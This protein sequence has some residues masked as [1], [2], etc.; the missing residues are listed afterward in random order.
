MRGLTDRSPST[1][2]AHEATVLIGGPRAAGGGPAPGLLLLTLWALVA[3]ACFHAPYAFTWAGFLTVV[4]LFALLQ[5]AKAVRWRP[6][7]YSGLAVGFLIA[8]VRLSFF[9]TIFS[10]G[11]VS[12]WLVFA[13]WIGL[14]V[15]LAR[16][17]LRRLPRPW[18]WLV[19]PF[20]WTGLE[21]FRSELYYLRFAWLTPGFAFAWSLW[22]VP[23]K[24]AGVYGVGFLL[25]A[26]AAASA[27]LWERSKL[28][29]IGAAI[30]GV[31]GLCLLGFLS[32]AG[33][34]QPSNSSVSVAGVQLELPSEGE[35]LT[36]LEDLARRYPKADLLVL[37]EYTLPGPVPESLQAWCRRHQ[38]Y[39]LVGGKDPAGA[40]KFYNTAF[41]VG[42][43]GQIVFR[44]AKSV[45]IQFFKDGL[46]ARTQRVW[47]SPWGR[48]GI[49]ICYDL[50]YS[51]VT[52]RLVRLGAQALIVPTM[53]T[54]D[55]GGAEHNLHARVAPIRAAEYGLPVFR[56]ASSG[57]S[58]WVDP[59]GL[60][61]AQA[62]FPGEGAMI[63]G[64]L[65]M[66]DHGTLPWDRWLGPVSVVVAAGLLCWFIIS[67]LSH[68]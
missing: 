18:N 50:S 23:L 67:S 5:L 42:P 21:Y 1:G 38:R 6:A 37:S 22:E 60:V 30:A 48:I 40:G 7:F 33:R 20:V 14:F 2:L 26:V 36:K 32:G 47:D 3:A 44:Q 63:T 13:F 19:L 62:P 49:C 39:L 59:T 52:D 10:A 46:P 57:I 9:W 15:A 35:L 55:W 25:M 27:L 68:K 28:R 31:A 61:L 58:Q 53:D 11:A 56:L 66:P 45:P 34:G 64:V 16:L 43:T 29:A 17:C 8:A 41:V 65:K 4:Y 12:L 24:Y 51:R 54:A